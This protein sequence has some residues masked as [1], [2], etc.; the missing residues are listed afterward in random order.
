[1][2]TIKSAR[3]IEMMRR[4][5]KITAKVLTDADEERRGPA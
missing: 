5:G 1:M 2:I 3:E 4:S